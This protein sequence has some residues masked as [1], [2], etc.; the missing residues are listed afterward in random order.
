MAVNLAL[1]GQQ[2]GACVFSLVARKHTSS[3]SFQP[4]QQR[5]WHLTG[6]SATREPAT[7]AAVPP[8][9]HSNSS[10]ATA[11]PLAHVILAYIY[12]PD[13]LSPAASACIAAAAAVLSLSSYLQPA[14]IYVDDEAKLTLHGLVQ[15]YVM[16][17]E[18]EKNRKLTDLLDALDFNQVFTRFTLLL[19]NDIIMQCLA[20]GSYNCSACDSSVVLHP[21]QLSV[22]SILRFV[23]AVALR[24]CCYAVCSCLAPTAP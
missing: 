20:P 15:H 22:S 5:S 11:N 7:A 18:E 10:V 2:H 9:P 21:L 1:S 4:A 17:H 13:W 12:I 6:L 23:A 16:L 8:C 14:E 19:P 24:T 3:V